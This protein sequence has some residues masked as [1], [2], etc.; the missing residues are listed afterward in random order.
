MA[1]RV[2]DA[3]LQAFKKVAGG[4][5]WFGLPITQTLNS[6]VTL[7]VKADILTYV[8]NSSP[9]SIL[10]GRVRYSDPP[11]GALHCMG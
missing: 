7:S 1:E 10:A 9:G 5:L 4:P 8:V 11:S 6:L 3:A 2:S